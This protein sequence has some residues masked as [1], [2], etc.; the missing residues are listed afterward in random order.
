MMSRCKHRWIVVETVNKREIIEEMKEIPWTR[1]TE[2]DRIV[3]GHSRGSIT[4]DIPN[5]GSIALPDATGFISNR[6]C[7]LC[8]EVKDD[9]GEWERHI[10]N[11]YKAKK[12]Q[13]E[14]LMAEK[15]EAQKIYDKYKKGH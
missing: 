13:S 5:L 4:V 7:I 15:V 12:E 11:V 9:I 3:R 10:L 1:D 14:K 6:V 2:F 8:E